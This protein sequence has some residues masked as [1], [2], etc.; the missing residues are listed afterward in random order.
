[1][2]GKHDHPFVPALNTAGFA[3]SVAGQSKIVAWSE[4]DFGAAAEAFAS[5]SALVVGGMAFMDIG[6]P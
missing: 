2:S 1:M 3:P 4:I 6:W 5:F